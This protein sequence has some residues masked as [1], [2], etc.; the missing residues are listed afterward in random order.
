MKIT[1]DQ[2][3]EFKFQECEIAGDKCWLITPG[4][5]NTEW[6]EENAW[7]RSAIIRQSDGF[8]VSQGFKKFTNWGE[9][10]LFQPP[11]RLKLATSWTARV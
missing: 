8:C 4:H 7:M 9:K 6:T 10:P 2:Y 11:V 5:I 3:P 1:P